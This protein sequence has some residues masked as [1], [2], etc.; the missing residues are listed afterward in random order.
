MVIREIYEDILLEIFRSATIGIGGGRG[1]FLVENY[2]LELQANPKQ[3]CPKK[4]RYF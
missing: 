4:L 3:S 2:Y 1:Q